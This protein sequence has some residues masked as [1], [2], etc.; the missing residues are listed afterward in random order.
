MEPSQPR[1]QAVALSDGRI[2]AVG[3]TDE[4]LGMAGPSCRKLDLAGLT[5]VPG[6]NDAHMHIMGLGESLLGADVSPSAGAVS[7]P[8]LLR[9][10][11][12]WAEAH[13]TALWVRGYGY[14][15]NAFPDVRH[16]TAAELDSAFPDRP[17]ALHYASAHGVVANMAAL[18]FVGILAEID[19]FPNGV[20][21]RDDTGKLT[22]LLLEAAMVLLT[23]AIP[24]LSGSERTEA[25]TLAFRV[26]A[27]RG[28]TA[29]SE[30]GTGC[31]SLDADVSAYRAALD[32]GAPVRVTLCPEAATLW[33]AQDIP[34]RGDV[35]RGYGLDDASSA[36]SG[37]LRLGALK[38][39]ADGALTTRT[40]AISAPFADG[41]GSGVLV[42]DPDEL[43]AYILNGD[44]RGW[45]IATHAIGDRAVAT[46]LSAYEMTTNGLNRRHRV[47]HAML[48]DRALIERMRAS[49]VVAVMQ[50]EFLTAFGEAYVRALG[51][52][53]A[54][55]VNPVAAL[56]AADVPVAFSSDCPVV[57]GAPLDGIWASMERTAASGRIL[58]AEERVDVLTALR[59]YTE[60]AACATWDDE[61]VGRIRQGMRADLVALTALPGDDAQ[62]EPRVAA[63]MV[64]GR[65][66]MGHEALQ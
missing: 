53:R 20:I 39:Y 60:T 11:Q 66:V 35:E 55:L 23:S 27:S 46:A 18:C 17:V 63:T 64:G 7:I 47:E 13:P 38:L 40:A 31:R 50:P 45:Q 6:F 57:T 51:E 42:H 4:I 24:P 26:L 44:A 49:G 9:L 1:A 62:V 22:G 19:V 29:A 56:L 8:S 5:L 37:G 28:V 30:M 59:A 65:V 10:L 16:I 48:L 52:E 3:T 58:G 33:N 14:D 34:D 61:A 12:E 15:H 54:G 32:R 25:L 2:A 36:E 21:G 43:T 41:S